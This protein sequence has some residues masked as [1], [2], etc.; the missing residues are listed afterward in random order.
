MSAA[1]Q[2][3]RAQGASYRAQTLP[4]LPATRPQ[5]ADEADLYDEHA[6]LKVGI[7]DLGAAQTGAFRDCRT[8]SAQV[9]SGHRGRAPAFDAAVRHSRLDHE[10]ALDPAAA[11]RAERHYREIPSGQGHSSRFVSHE[12]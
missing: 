10:H 6:L 3:R 4:T 8:S 2:L 12:L 1:P 11:A 5:P 7:F 9:Q